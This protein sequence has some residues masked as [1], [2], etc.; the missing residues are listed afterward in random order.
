MVKKQLTQE[1]LQQV[2]EL[3]SQYSKLYFEVGELE[4]QK[5]IFQENLNNIEEQ[6]KYLFL[7]LKKI[8]EKE[9]SFAQGLNEK[10]G[11]GTININNGEIIPFE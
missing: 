5:R 2:Q 6:Q 10:Y 3:Q 4:V 8:Q 1:E 9:T 7:D 11:K